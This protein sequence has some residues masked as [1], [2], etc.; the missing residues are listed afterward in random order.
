MG[1]GYRAA[2]PIA[3][4]KLRLLTKLRVASSTGTWRLNISV[5]C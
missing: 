3:I 2:E 1:V 4:L 5:G